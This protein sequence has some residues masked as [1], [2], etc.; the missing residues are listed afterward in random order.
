MISLDEISVCISLSWTG[1]GPCGKVGER[2]NMGELRGEVELRLKGERKRV[3]TNDFGNAEYSLFFLLLRLK[4]S[5]SSGL[6]VS[7][8]T[9][10][11]TLDRVNDWNNER[12]R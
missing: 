3:R 1:V 8:S 5:G 7:R 12:D 11:L 4:E 2:R 10:R 9:G 6:T